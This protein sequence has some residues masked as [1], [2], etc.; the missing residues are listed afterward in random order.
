MR[1][2]SRHAV[3]S[4]VSYAK[5]IRTSA[6]KLT[7]ENGP[8]SP[9]KTG[10]G[11]SRRNLY[12]A[13]LGLVCT[14][15]YY[16]LVNSPSRSAPTLS[17]T[18]L[19]PSH[20]TP[21]KVTASIPCTPYTKLLT[22]S[23]PPHLI[24]VPDERPNPIYCIYV[25]DSDIQVER[26]YTP[27]QGIDAQGQAHFWVK[28]YQGGEVGRWLHE[29]KLGEEIEIR[30]PVPCWP[31]RDGEWDDIIMISGGTGITPFYQL[32]HSVFSKG[33]AVPQT[34]FTLLHS[35]PRPSDLPPG[36]IL[37]RLQEW[38]SQYPDSFALRLYVDFM[39]PNA[40]HLYAAKLTVGR[41]GRTAVREA[42]ALRS[43]TGE[44]WWRRLWPGGETKT[45]LHGRK[46]LFLVCGPEPMIAAI[47]GPRGQGMRQGKV[48]GV[49]GE[50]G[51]EGEQVF[52]M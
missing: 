6:I 43:P 8:G 30:G 21:V 29:R 14:S 38:S 46:I 17:D 26:P 1:W 22:F 20:F 3:G 32:M 47:A 13:G 34:R 11:R 7:P 25:K 19:S 35:S 28:R 37:D 39:D 4:V 5:C 16:L 45:D 18:P 10:T 52:K 41:I 48:G 49:L 40:N 12:I 27:L 31:W 36:M 51:A 15:L 33:I 24:P 44:A 42:V 9:A 23:I 50:L 2:H